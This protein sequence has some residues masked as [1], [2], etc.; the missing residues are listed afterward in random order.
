MDSSYYTISCVSC[1]KVW[2]EHETCTTCKD[3]GSALDVKINLEIVKKGLNQFNLEHTPLSA[4]K[5][6]D[7]YPIN[8]RSQ[9]VSLSEGNTPLYPT[10]KIG[11]K[12]GLS[13]LF[14]KNEGHNPTGVFKDRGSMVEI[15]KALE[16]K[17]KAVCVASTGNMAASVAAYSSQA[18][19]PCYILVPEGT[20][21]GKLSQ[22]LVYGGK[23]IQVRGG[24]ADCV[25]LAEQLSK[26]NN[27]YLAGDYAFR[28]EGAKSTAFEIIEQLHWKTPDVVLVPVGCGTNL[29]GIWKGFLELYQLGL[30]DSTPRVI[31]VQPLGCNTICGAF[32]ENRHT[33]DIV[34]KPKTIASAVGIGVPQDDIK[35]LR[36]LHH[37]NGYAETASDEKILEA[38]RS[39]AEEE[40]IFTE[41]SGAIPIAVL[42]SLLQK[43]IIT[44]DQTIVCVAT[45][46]GLKDPKA[47][48]SSFSEP[49]SIDPEI[50]QVEHFLRSGISSIRSAEINGPEKIVFTKLPEKASLQ[51]LIKDEFGYEPTG[52]ILDNISHESAELLRKGKDVTKGDL[53]SIIEEAVENTTIP[54]TPLKIIDFS[55]QDSYI[56]NPSGEITISFLRKKITAKAEGVGPVDALIKA[57]SK[58]LLEE[59]NFRPILHDFHVDVASSQENALVKVKMEMKDTQGNQVTAKA[60]NPDI[61]IASVN[62]FVKGFNLLF[63][64]RKEKKSNRK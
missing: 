15:T 7:F 46:T 32:Q 29:C 3:C 17:A 42:P 48:I 13:Q 19:L 35:C 58:A 62:A 56:K 34:E 22:T 24:Y 64:R 21:I 23:L 40:S 20:P 9:I 36:A 41:P 43:N 59:T 4:R 33:C 47:A 10:K 57:I 27:Y 30:I 44:P 8:N 39:L 16:L 52:I 45:G 50:E 11:A 55:L 54:E 25:Q 51:F 26:R 6:L 60:S 28:A 5:Y 53:L 12:L 49:P 18:G 14:V 61:I 37:S 38:Q 63:E 31:G 2:D 1:Q